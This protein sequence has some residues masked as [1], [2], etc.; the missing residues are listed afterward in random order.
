MELLVFFECQE[1]GV[2]FYDLH[3]AGA[4]WSTSLWLVKELTNL[5][6]PLCDAAWVPESQR[7]RP[8][9]LGHMA[10]GAAK[11]LNQLLQPPYEVTR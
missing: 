2:K 10:T 8:L 1:R 11:W 9:M 6:D 4:R 7:A 5:H 3:E